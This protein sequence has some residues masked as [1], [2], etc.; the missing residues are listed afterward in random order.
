ML[1]QHAAD[2]KSFGDVKAMLFPEPKE[3]ANLRFLSASQVGISL[4]ENNQVLLM[5]SSQRVNRN[6]TASSMLVVLFPEDICDF[7]LERL[8]EF[9]EGEKLFVGALGMLAEFFFH[10]YFS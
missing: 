4:R 7:P 1:V 9:D 6:V 10:Q 2:C 8:A 3:N 5:F